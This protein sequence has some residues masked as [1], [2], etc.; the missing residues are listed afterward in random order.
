MGL[1]SKK[2]SLFDPTSK[3]TGAHSYNTNGKS[4]LCSQCGGNLF[5]EGTALLNTAGMT[6]FSLDWAN[7]SAT[8][9]ICAHC[10]HIQWFLQT[11]QMTN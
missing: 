7:K 6:F 1:F 2:R 11:P 10:G 4:I 8:I 5:E 9:L 3:P